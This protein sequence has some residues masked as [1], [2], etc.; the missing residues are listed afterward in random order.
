MGSTVVDDLP[1]ISV[2]IPVW[3]SPELIAKCLAAIGSQTYPRDRFEVLVV[4]NGST[5]ET[6]E[7]VR[8]F[9]AVTLLSEPVAS[10][11]RARNR[12]LRSA[13]GECVAFTDADC[14]PDREWLAAAARA[15]RRY[16]LAGVFAGQVDLFRASSSGSV[17]CEK[18]EYAFEFDQARNVRYGVCVTANWMSRRATL[19]EF[20]GFDESVKSGGDWHLCG[21]IQAAG[22][23][24]VYV[25]EMCVAH[26]IR[27]S[28]AQLAA[29]RRRTIG[30]R[31]QSTRKR[32]RFLWCSAVVVKRSLKR[33]V[34]TAADTRFSLL[35]RVRIIG[36]VMALWAVGIAELVRLACGGEAKRA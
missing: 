8:S 17:A 33:I 2:V 21:R 10:S 4:D 7:V 32:W 9:P 6:A 31:W 16:P 14:I 13:R 27:G 22:H 35:D 12:G 15:A 24:V 26:P 23:P 18:Y 30:G 19:L 34:V 25:P 36:V 20:G 1:F 3:N 5:D 11:Y 29:K 28:L